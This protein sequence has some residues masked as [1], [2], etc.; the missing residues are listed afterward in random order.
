MFIVIR[1]MH[2]NKDSCYEKVNNSLTCCILLMNRHL[3]VI[4]K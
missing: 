3:V 1:I 4:M 2:Y